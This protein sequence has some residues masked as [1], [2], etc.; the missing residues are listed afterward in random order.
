MVTGLTVDTRVRAALGQLL[1]AGFGEPQ[2][3]RWF[4]V[5]L[6]T[7]ARYVPSLARRSVRKGIGGW[8][9]VLVGG[10]SLPLSDLAVLDDLEA[11]VDGGFL[12]RQGD[13]VRARVAL[14]PVMGLLLASDRIDE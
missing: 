1:Q 7:D 3:A 6:V 4:G 8:I 12:E 14:L 9:A 5:P 2:V 13:R 11:L 10:E